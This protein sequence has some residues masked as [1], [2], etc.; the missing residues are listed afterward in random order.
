MIWTGTRKVLNC[1]RTTLLEGRANAYQ[2]M[3]WDALRTQGILLPD[4]NHLRVEILKYTE[5]KW[6]GGY[7]DLPEECRGDFPPDVTPEAIQRVVGQIPTRFR[8]TNCHGALLIE[9]AHQVV[10]A[11]Q[12]RIVTFLETQP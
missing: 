1:S 11:H 5:A 12:D 6:S 3:L 2:L 10:T 4:F 7:Q 9:A 8:I